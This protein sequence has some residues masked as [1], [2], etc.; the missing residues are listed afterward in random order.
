MITALLW[1]LIVLGFSTGL[2]LVWSW[3]RQP[4]D[5]PTSVGDH[6]RL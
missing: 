2:W 6:D 1:V 4:D 5:Q 3:A